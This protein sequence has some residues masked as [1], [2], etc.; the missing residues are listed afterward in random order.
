[1]ASDTEE[2]DDEADNRPDVRAG[3]EASLSAE[4]GEIKQRDG[5]REDDIDA[6][7]ERDRL[8]NKASARDE[9]DS[10]GKGEDYIEERERC[11][12]FGGGFKE[13][14]EGE[15]GVKNC[16]GAEEDRNPFRNFVGP[17]NK[18]NADR[19]KGERSDDFF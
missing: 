7:Y 12:E 2:A 19:E 3:G 13:F 8:L 5:A 15:E 16:A 18:A 4:G 14:N 11:S 10:D 1:M 9:E 6:N 17:N